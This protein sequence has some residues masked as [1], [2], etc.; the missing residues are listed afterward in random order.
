[1]VQWYMGWCHSFLP[2]FR[3]GMK[4]NVAIPL[5]LSSC[6]YHLVDFWGLVLPKAGWGHLHCCHAT[7]CCKW[8]H[9]P[10]LPPSTKSQS[11]GQKAKRNGIWTSYQGRLTNE[12]ST[13]WIKAAWKN[14]QSASIDTGAGDIRVDFT[15]IDR[16][17]LLTEQAEKTIVFNN[18]APPTN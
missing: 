16:A 3:R 7:Q 10:G 8:Q 6:H 1:M 17:L 11:P 14:I 4:A 9:K 15:G 12:V 18:S 2:M 5:E 13:P